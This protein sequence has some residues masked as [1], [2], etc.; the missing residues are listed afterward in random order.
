M[1]YGTLPKTKKQKL[2]HGPAFASGA[3][4]AE[5]LMKDLDVEDRQKLLA[6][7]V[8]LVLKGLMHE[9]IYWKNP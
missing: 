4:M 7:I 9:R 1:F 6:Y 8:L 5:F 3:T 2:K